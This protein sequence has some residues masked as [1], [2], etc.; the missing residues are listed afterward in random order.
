M[1][2]GGRVAVAGRDCLPQR[3]LLLDEPHCVGG[4]S[5][6]GSRGLRVRRKAR[7]MA[8]GSTKPRIPGRGEE[9]EVCVMTGRWA[10][11]VIAIGL[12]LGGCA[13]CPAQQRDVEQLIDELKVGHVGFLTFGGGFSRA[14]LGE[15]EEA[16]EQIRADLADIRRRADAAWLIEQE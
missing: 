16:D 1:G 3:S 6:W 4:R 8:S 12:L 2:G 13:E 7:I 14:M 11:L 10:W 15:G 9:P 5:A